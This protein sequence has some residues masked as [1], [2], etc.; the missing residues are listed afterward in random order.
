MN[1]YDG[2]DNYDDDLFCDAKNNGK[3][4][5]QENLFEEFFLHYKTVES[6]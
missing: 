3:Q 6:R 5:E 1:A 4:K 2:D